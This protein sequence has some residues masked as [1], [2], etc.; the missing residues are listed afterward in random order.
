DRPDRPHAGTPRHAPQTARD[1]GFRKNKDNAAFT[2]ATD[3]PGGER[4]AAAH[5]S[6]EH[7]ARVPSPGTHPPRA[8]TRAPGAAIRAQGAATRSPGTAA[9]PPGTAARPPGTATRPPGTGSRTAGYGNAGP[10]RPQ[11]ADLTET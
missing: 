6:R 4:P 3:V 1:V 2:I 10:A 8:A 5:R 9:R 11:R 7:S